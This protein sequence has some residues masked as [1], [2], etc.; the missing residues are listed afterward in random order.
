MP[1]WE[2]EEVFLKGVSA[3]ALGGAVRYAYS[4]VLQALGVVNYDTHAASMHV[5]LRE[6][7]T[8]L[9]AGIFSA[10]TTLIIG[11]FFGVLI[12]FAFRYALTPHR[13]LLKGALLGVFIWLLE[14]GLGGEAFR[15]PP[16]LLVSLPDVGAILIGQTLYGI[17]VAYFLKRLGIFADHTGK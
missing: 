13:Y 15:Y 9:A 7:P 17:A 4:E 16:G 6:A 3:G 5:I 12:A 11:A 8:D 1:K 10:A 2:R 14:F